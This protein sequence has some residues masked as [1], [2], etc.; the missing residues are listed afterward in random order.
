MTPEQQAL[1]Y[2]LL[3]DE[4]RAQVATLLADVEQLIARRTF[5]ILRISGETGSA[6]AAAATHPARGHLRRGFPEALSRRRAKGKPRKTVRYR[7]VRKKVLKSRRIL[8]DIITRLRVGIQSL[9]A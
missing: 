7:M 3:T 9:A 1:A 4:E 6:I 2:K 5:E 8:T